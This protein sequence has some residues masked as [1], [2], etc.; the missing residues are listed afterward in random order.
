MYAWVSLW[1]CGLLACMFDSHQCI[2]PLCLPQ[3]F[4]LNRKHAELVL[5][6]QAV[7]K[8]F[9]RNCYTTLERA[10]GKMW[11]RVCYSGGLLALH[12]L[13]CGLLWHC[14]GIVAS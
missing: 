10:N 3:W 5:A 9:Q 2:Y 4:V 11:E 13:C 14:C 1:I 7:E 12:Y 8:L 6:D